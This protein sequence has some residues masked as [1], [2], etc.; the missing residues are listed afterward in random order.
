MR[1]VAP[2]LGIVMDIA[3]RERSTAAIGSPC[4][5][6]SDG[7]ARRRHSEVV[8][9]RISLFVV[10][11]SPSYSAGI[12]LFV[13][14]LLFVAC[15]GS[16]RSTASPATLEAATTGSTAFAATATSVSEAQTASVSTGIAQTGASPTPLP[17]YPCEASAT[18]KCSDFPSRPEA[19]RIYAKHGGNGWSALIPDA[20]GVVCP[21]L[22]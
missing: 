21:Q 11:L 9:A 22:P 8:V 4:V 13:A 19:G 3:R 17:T 18:C 1:F 15:S 5:H 20:S 6:N 7:S 14:F 12:M 10:K 16:H 2:S